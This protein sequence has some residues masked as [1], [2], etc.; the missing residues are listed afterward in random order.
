MRKLLG[1]INNEVKGLHAHI[2]LFTETPF[3]PFLLAQG[4]GTINALKVTTATRINH[5]SQ[6]SVQWDNLTELLTIFTV[7]RRDF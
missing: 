2:F 5:Q 3:V 4:L 7:K 1:L 6:W